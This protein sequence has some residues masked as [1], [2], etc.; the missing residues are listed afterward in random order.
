VDN[1]QANIDQVREQ[2]AA[3]AG[4]VGRQADD[5]T[6]VAVSKTVSPE[7]IDEALALGVSMFGESKLQEAKAKIPLV[8]GRARWHMIGHLQTNKA[9]D[10]VELFELIHSV[11]SLKLAVVLDKWAEHAGKRQS[12]LLEVNV[13]GEASKFGIKPEDLNAVLEQIAALPRLEVRGL[14]TLAP[15]AED[16][17]KARPYFR[18][19]RELR[20]TVGLRELS[21]GMSNDFEIGIEE[22]ATIVRVGTAIF[23]ERKRHEPEE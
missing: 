1:L 15:F 11:D 12:V 4:R 17:E 19:L 18:R 2:I 22:G 6:L 3:A 21:M 14:M 10:T 9:R 23:G 20:D 5:V 7:R 16:A 13:S 8:S